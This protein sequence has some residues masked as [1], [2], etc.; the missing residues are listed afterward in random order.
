[1]KHTLGCIVLLVCTAAGRPVLA[2]NVHL[3][4]AAMRER[5]DLL[6]RQNH[7]LQDSLMRLP[8][9]G[10]A[11]VVHYAGAA[12]TDA[13]AFTAMEQRL[14]ELEARLAEAEQHSAESEPPEWYE[15]GSDLTMTA[16]WNHGLELSTKN[17]DFRVHV[18][19]RTQFDSGWFDADQN[20][21]NNINVPYMDGVDFRRARLRIDGALYEVIEWACEY[22]LVNAFRVAGEPGSP[23]RTVPAFTDMWVTFKELPLA[24]N[25]R[26]G[27]QK[28]AIGFEHMVSSRFLP[29][30]ER[31]YNQDTFYGGLFNGFQ[32]GIAAFDTY[33]DDEIGTW[34]LGLF[35]PVNNVFASNATDGDYSIV[36][37]FTRLLW[38]ADDGRGLL[39]VG[40]SGVQ[41][42]TVADRIVFRTR[43]AIRTGLA[44]GWPVPASTGTIAGDDMQWVNAE[45]AA[46]YGPF[47]LQGEYLV[48][49]LHDAAPIVGGVV[50]PSVGTVTYHGGY[51]QALVYLTGDHDHYNKKT[52]A[53]DRVIPNESFFLVRDERGFF[54]HGLGAW[55]IGA[56]YNYLDLN[57]NGIDGGILHNGTLGINWFMNPNMKVQFDYIA[58]HRDA[59]LPRDLGDGWIHGWGTRLAWDF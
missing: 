13:A 29:F 3:E 15:V 48:S 21:Q 57:D 39:H 52:G 47:T 38:Y 34:N 11:P 55:Q 51:I 30:L 50:Q 45:L 58:T 10:A 44:S 37:R 27:N 18:G 9:T 35:K 5:I 56:R 20:V 2:Q 12:N 8:P 49:D 53:F 40:M 19:G 41:Q 22:D 7:A 6:E 32:P 16:K 24:G 1:V 26:V 43:D 4:L 17:K 54:C 28:P 46:V 59:P 33:G 23:D 36:S 14:A 31:S 25:I 42:S